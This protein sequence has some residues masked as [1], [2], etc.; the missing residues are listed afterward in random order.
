M[1]SGNFVSVGVAAFAAMICS[2]VH[3]AE[4]STSA[5][6]AA[7]TSATDSGSLAEI[8]VTAQ[9]RSETA[10]RTPADVS[11]LRSEDL[12]QD[13][14]TDLK[15]AEVALPATK[16]NVE[17]AAVQAVIRGVGS[18]IDLTYVA[19]SVA[20]NFN[21]VFLTRFASSAGF[22]DISRIEVLPGPQGTLYGRSA[23]GGVINVVT[24]RP[25][26]DT[27]TDI[28][29]DY[30]NYSTKHVTLV[31]NL[32]ISATWS[33]RGALDYLDNNGYNNNGTYSTDS[34]AG[35]LSSLYQ[36]DAFSAF[37]TASYSENRVRPSPTQYVPYPNGD[38][39]SFPPHDP[40]TAFFYPPN[41]IS[42]SDTHGVYENS[43]VS[44]QLDWDLGP[45]TVSY[46][47]GLVRTIT[48]D[49]RIVS[50]FLFP[51]QDGINQFSNELRVTGNTTAG[52]TFLGGLYQLWNKSFQDSVFGPNL[53]GGDVRTRADSYAAYGQGTYSVTDRVRVTA[54]ARVSRDDLETHD[55]TAFYPIGPTLE[56]GVV[57]FSF[58]D[59]WKKAGWKLG[60]EYD[61]TSTS[62]LYATI[63]TGF[64]PGSFNATLPNA[65]S[66]V[67]PQTMIGYTMGLKN[68]F[69]DGK[70]RLNAEGFLYDYDN[71][72]IQA[73]DFQTGNTSLLNAPKV[74]IDGADLTFAISPVKNLQLHANLTYLDAQIR[75]FS[76]GTSATTLVNYAGYQLPFSPPYSG[77]VG[78]NYSFTLG[79]AGSLSLRTDSYI[80][81]AYWDFFSHTSNLRQGGYTKTD[82]SLTYH[83]RSDRWDV[84][85]YG[86]NLENTASQGAAGESGR[87]YPYAG[88]VYVQPPRLYGVRFHTKLGN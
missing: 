48:S 66:L 80:S 11:V 13:G 16:L 79:D 81:A 73:A 22:Y 87:P 39:Y 43:L 62:L 76:A 26:Q 67:Q 40:Y 36:G 17:N 58:S 50:A 56:R 42:N 47:P 25:T 71:L 75:N 9:K 60:G 70:M 45:V 8:V 63:Q 6:G 49:D 20:V 34:I 59:N 64:D 5:E 35:R 78:A 44:G 53:S 37:L 83:A 52:L 10:Q 85:L 27:S 28:L 69:W 29:V 23:V 14:I 12:I 41:G 72:I 55:S 18:E 3:G 61:V 4:S 15:S 77:T 24:N 32:P 54:G 57:P 51:V 33:I 7:D 82:V 30:G 84:G 21:N 86:N 68:S 38:G 46:L 31:Q 1:N 65:G 88:V 2:Q 74:R 19:E